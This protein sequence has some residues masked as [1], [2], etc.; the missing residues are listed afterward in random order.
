M[1]EFMALQDGV[2]NSIDNYGIMKPTMSELPDWIRTVAIPSA[3]ESTKPLLDIYAE[4]LQLRDD[5][6]RQHAEIMH[7]LVELHLL[8]R[9]WYTRFTYWFWKFLDHETPKGEL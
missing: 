9:P 3:P 7:Q 6:Q 1:G 5:M 2:N 8:A 4:L